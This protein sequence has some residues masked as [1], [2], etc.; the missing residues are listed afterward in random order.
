MADTK[1]KPDAA[2]VEASLLFVV[3]PEG[4]EEVPVPVPED[5]VG[6]V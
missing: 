5:P 3:L 6:D 2:N 4:E 1:N